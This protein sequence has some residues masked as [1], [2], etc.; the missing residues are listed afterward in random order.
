MGP[1]GRG[2]RINCLVLTRYDRLGSSS[3]LRFL[4]YLPYLRAQGVQCTVSPLFGDDYVRDLYAGRRNVLGVLRAYGRRILQLAQRRR[5]DCLWVEKELLPWLPAFV[6]EAFLPP[7][8]PLILDYDDAVFHRYDEHSSSAVRLALGHK[9]DSLMRRASVVTVGN[10]YLAERARASGARQVEWFPTAV[11]LSRYPT[12]PTSESSGTV[13]VG[14]IG[15]PATAHYLQSICEPLLALKA[16]FCLRCVAIGA[17]ENQLRGTPFE[18][19]EWSEQTEAEQLRRLDIGIMPLPDEPWARGKCGYKLVQYMATGLP[20]VASPVGM[21]NVLVEPGLNGFLAESSTDW[22]ACLE[23]LVVDA[24]LRNRMGRM[25]RDKVE[26]GYCLQLQ[27][28][29]LRRLMQSVAA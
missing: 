12:K 3:R 5:V 20:V 24:D 7:G 27:A 15:S 25:G 13:M 6:E 10:D 22:V 28:P 11:D 16:R 23:K 18:A 2:T 17:R 14:W 8:I 19:W 4:Q 21:N 9:L 26:S 29:R 1:S